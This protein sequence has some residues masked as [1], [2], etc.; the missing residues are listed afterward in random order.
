M[1]KIH[2]ILLTGV[3]VL[4]L[5][6]CHNS[7]A[8]N[9][10]NNNPK[11]KVNMK[12]EKVALP[13]ATDA[14][15]PV[16]SKQTVELHYGKHH[17]AYVDNLNKLVVGT[18]FENSDLETVVKE[19]D[20]AIFNN[21]GQVLNHNLY[22]TSFKQGGSSVPKG[23]LGDAINAQYGSFEK[24]QEEFNAAGA[25]VF[26]SGWVW[27]AKDG[28]GKLSIE[29][30]SNAG[31]PITKGLTPILGFDVW[32]HSYY[33]DYQNRRADHLK[34]LWKIIDWDVVSARY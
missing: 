16:I 4:T 21:A 2:S 27:L 25:S 15:E 17:Q 30:E 5:F 1:K 12:F 19:S 6:S 34:E 13:Y 28:S 31:N 24:F 9:N 22:F 20:G 14:L 33:L 8:N 3:L 29:K 23:A 11:N 26:G 7:N 32:E 10:E 18:K